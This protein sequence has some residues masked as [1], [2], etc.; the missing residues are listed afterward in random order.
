MFKF[1]RNKL[2]HCEGRGIFLRSYKNLDNYSHLTSSIEKD[3]CN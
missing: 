2:M 3:R 1:N